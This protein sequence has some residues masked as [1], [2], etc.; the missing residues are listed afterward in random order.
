MPFAYKED[1][2]RKN[3]YFEFKELVGRQAPLSKLKTTWLVL[4]DIGLTD[5]QSTLVGRQFFKAISRRKR[6]CASF[7]LHS[8]SIGS[9]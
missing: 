9:F 8:I 7:I 6:F 1:K 5:F 2:R 4:I 3:K